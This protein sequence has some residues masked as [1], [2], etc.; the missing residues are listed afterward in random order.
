MKDVFHVLPATGSPLWLLGLIVALLLA[1]A[2]GLATIALSTRGAP[3]ELSAEGLRIRSPFY[4]R[5]ISWREIDATTVRA[6][7]L[8]DEP[9]LRPGFRSNGIGLPGYQ[10]G[11]FSLKNGRDGL[12]FLTDRGRVAV[13]PTRTYT[14]LLSVEDPAAFVAAVGKWSAQA[15]P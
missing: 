5:L 13:I 12:L 2:A 9:G 10:A 4:G 14:V 15:K 11:W 8:A 1:L 7:D 6:V 3:V